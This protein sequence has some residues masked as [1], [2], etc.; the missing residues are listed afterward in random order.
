MLVLCDTDVSSVGSYRD[1]VIL[2]RWHVSPPLELY[3]GNQ[4]YCSLKSH[5]DSVMIEENTLQNVN[6]S[7]DAIF[8]MYQYEDC[9]YLSGLI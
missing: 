6:R 2:L 8:L 1:I 3:E 5:G 9:R 7:Y 4:K